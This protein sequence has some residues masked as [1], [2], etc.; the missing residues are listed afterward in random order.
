[1]S[2]TKAMPSLRACPQ[3]PTLIGLESEEDGAILEPDVFLSNCRKGPG[4]TA[5]EAKESELECPGP[6]L[7]FDSE[8]P[9]NARSETEMEVEG[10][11]VGSCAR[12]GSG[13]IIARQDHERINA[14]RVSSQDHAEA[15][16]LQDMEFADDRT[17]GGG[18]RHDSLLCEEVF[19][20]QLATRAE[21]LNS[22]FQVSPFLSPPFDQFSLSHC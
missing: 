5:S 16:L 10:E 11:G 13:G 21:L 15:F 12:V 1:M 22:A 7:T 17:Q 9:F 20:A 4:G 14:I 8:W 6:C 2:N 3:S 18:T 19:I